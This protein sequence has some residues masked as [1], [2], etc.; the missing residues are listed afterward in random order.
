MKRPKINLHD[1]EWVVLS[2]TDAFRRGRVGLGLGI[3]Q[4]AGAA[5]F[6]LG[7]VVGGLLAS[8][9]WRWVFWVNVPLK[10]V[11]A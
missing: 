4:I 10:P 1:Y 9:S 2:V 5:G 8:I 7:P 6:L 3:N 11:A